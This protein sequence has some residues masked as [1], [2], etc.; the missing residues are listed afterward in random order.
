M[1]SE[2]FGVVVSNVHVHDL[3]KLSNFQLLC[4]ELQ[5]LKHFI[6]LVDLAVA[7]LIFFQNWL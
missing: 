6:G 3:I 1:S 7:L 4:V 2:I 5:Y